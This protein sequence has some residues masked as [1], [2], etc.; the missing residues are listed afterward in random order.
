[1]NRFIS[2]DVLVKR[3]KDKDKDKDNHMIR[4]TMTL[5][6][7]LFFVDTNLIFCGGER[8]SL[9]KSIHGFFSLVLNLVYLLRY[10]PVIHP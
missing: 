4:M 2:W 9:F 8:G 5:K 7:A 3:D 10:A 1:M 6:L